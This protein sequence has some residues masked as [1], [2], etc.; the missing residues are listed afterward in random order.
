MLIGQCCVLGIA[1]RT[2]FLRTSEILWFEKAISGL[3]SDFHLPLLNEGGCLAL[4]IRLSWLV[5]THDSTAS[6][7]GF[8]SAYPH[9]VLWLLKSSRTIHDFSEGSKGGS[10]N[11]VGGGFWTE[12]M[13]ICFSSTENVSMSFRSYFDVDCTISPYFTNIALLC[14]SC[15][16]STFVMPS[17]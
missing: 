11:R 7:S 1:L 17:M 16:L 5:S 8:V 10:S 12:V 4:C 13:L 3:Y 14:F 2:P 6:P 15:D 9:W